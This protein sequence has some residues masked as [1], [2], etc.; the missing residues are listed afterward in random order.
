MAIIEDLKQVTPRVLS[1]IGTIARSSMSNTSVLAH[2]A[3]NR[4]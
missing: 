2:C 1:V 4:A 3:S